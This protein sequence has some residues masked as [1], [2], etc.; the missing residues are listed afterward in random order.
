M[1]ESTAFTCEARLNSVRRNTR[2]Y[3]C[4]STSAAVSYGDDYGWIENVFDTG[5]GKSLGSIDNPASLFF[6]TDK[7]VGGGPYVMSGQYYAC[8][9]RHNGGANFAF[10]DGH[11][12]W[13]KVAQ[14]NIPGE[15]PAYNAAFSYYPAGANRANFS[16]PADI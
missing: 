11:A 13:W 16:D 8:T 7:G 12:K 5:T 14:G 9:D 4:P 6:L 10:V 15:A 2:I 3:R 1:G